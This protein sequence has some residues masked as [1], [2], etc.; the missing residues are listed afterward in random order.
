[1]ESA[2]LHIPTAF[3]L[4]G[5]LD[6]RVLQAALEEVVARH[7]ALRTIFPQIDGRPVQRIL[8]AP[9]MQLTTVEAPRPHSADD[10]AR[11]LRGYVAEPFDIEQGPLLGAVLIAIEPTNHVLLIVCHHLVF[12]GWSLGILLNELGRL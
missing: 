8:T 1:P 7:E 9:S 10:L 12:D 11:L 5:E 6:S 3:D 4:R 2:A